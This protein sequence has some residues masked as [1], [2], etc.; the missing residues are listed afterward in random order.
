MAP[1]PYIVLLFV[2]CWAVACLI[3]VIRPKI[4]LSLTKKI[5]SLSA[6]TP[7]RF[8]QKPFY[9]LFW[10][11]DINNPQDEKVIR[12]IR[13]ENIKHL[14]VLL[15]IIA[16]I[17]LF[18]SEGTYEAEGTYPTTKTIEHLKIVFVVGLVLFLIVQLYG[19]LKNK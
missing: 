9:K 17:W 1:I 4:Y 7:L 18:R 10:S 8:L 6:E 14:I 2:F 13:I 12:M 3:A 16:V 5:I 11:I 19:K 15:M